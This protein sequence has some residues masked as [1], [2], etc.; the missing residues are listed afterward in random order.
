MPPATDDVLSFLDW[1]D[2]EVDDAGIGAW[3]NRYVQQPFDLNGKPLFSYVL[4]RLGE[5]RHIW[6]QRYHH[7]IIDSYGCHVLCRSLAAIYTAL[8]RGV[9]HALPVHS[10]LDFLAEDQAY[11]ASTA[12]EEH[13]A[14]WAERFAGLPAQRVFP[15]RGTATGGG[16]RT[17]DLPRGLC[18]RLAALARDHGCSPFH[19]HLAALYI[20]L[21][22]S[23]DADELVVGMPV[24]NRRTAAYKRTGG[25]F[26]SVSAMRL[27]FGR[28]LT[29]GGLC[30][31][32]ARELREC[33][34][35]QRFPISEINRAQG[36]DYAAAAQLFDIS[37]SYEKQDYSDIRFDGHS[38]QAVES[39]IA[40]TPLA[41]G[42]HLC[43]F[44]DESDVRAVVEYNHAHLDAAEADRFLR[45]WRHVLDSLPD[46]AAT[47]VWQFPLVS[48]EDR[49]RLAAFNATAADFGP[50]VTP[51]ELVEAQAAR[52]P[53]AVALIYDGQ[54]ISHGALN[55][56]ANALARVLAARGVGPGR[57]V[58]ICMDRGIDIVVAILAVLKA[59]GAYV[60]L[61][62]SYPSARLGFILEDCHPDVV[63]VD[64]LGSAR[65]PEGIE[66]LRVDAG[67]VADNPATV[68][69]SG[70]LAYVFYTSGSTGKPK[71]VMIRQESVFNLVRWMQRDFY[72]GRSFTELLTSSFS[73]DISVQQLFSALASGHTIHIAPEAVRQDPRT[74][75][76]YLRA[77]DIGILNVTP[78]LLAAMMEHDVQGAPALRHVILG[79]EA[80]PKALVEAFDH[81]R[82]ILYNFYGPTEVTVNA[83]WL[84]CDAG[85]A[86]R[87]DD[88]P[89]GRPMA[90]TAVHILDDRRQ[91]LPPGMQ[92]EVCIGGIGVADGYFNRPELTADRFIDHP[93]L[94]RL[95]RAGDVGLWL[96][97]GVVA[98][99]GRRDDQVKVRGY[100]IEL[101]EV[102]GALAAHPAVAE[103]VTV[104]RGEGADRHLASYYRLA[105]D[106]EATPAELR[107]WLSEQ[108]PAH[109]APSFLVALEALPLTP[110]GK[111]DRRA[112]PEPEAVV[113]TE[114][115]G[116]PASA[117][118][119]SVCALFG[120][121]LNQPDFA[122]EGDFFAH[123]GHSL[124]GTQLLVRLHKALNVRLPLHVLFANATPRALARII[125]T[126]APDVFSPIPRLADRPDHAPSRAQW[127]LWAQ[128][129]MQPEDA[130]SAVYHMPGVAELPPGTDVARL[131]A[132]ILAVVARHD[133]LRT[134]F[135]LGDEGLVQ[136]VRPMAAVE[137]R[138]IRQLAMSRQ[139]A[140]AWMRTDVAR[141]FDLARGPLFRVALI[142]TTDAP[143]SLLLFTMHHIISDGWSI[144]LMLD[145]IAELYAGR[146]PDE[147]AVRYRD[148]AAWHNA[149]LDDPA[150]EARHLPYW[151]DTL[152][153]APALALPTDHPRPAAR[154]F[155]GGHV[156][157]RWDAARLHGLD[158]LGQR[159]G[160][161]SFMVLAGLCALLLHRVS[162]QDDIV[163]GTPEAGRDHA[164]LKRV[165]GMFINMLCLRTRIEE[166]DTASDFLRQVREVCMEAQ[167]HRAY[168]FDGLVDRL[169]LPRDAGRHP[170]FDVTVTLEDADAMTLRL[171][172]EKVRVSTVETDTSKFDLTFAFTR[173][174]DGLDGRI[175]F[176]AALFDRST[177]DRLALRLEGIVAA[178]LADD[179]VPVASLSD[180][181]V[182]A[183]AVTAGFAALAALAG[184]EEGV[185]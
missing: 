67:E 50:V 34:R 59:G 85:T 54:S 125:E 115:A 47:P 104:A 132:A 99:L 110:Q 130:R 3:V 82:Q 152:E 90:N 150:F 178:V 51:K 81:S 61:D 184:R 39:E 173:D 106:A 13:R 36:L 92:G 93:E 5:G 171:D 119:A 44:H 77:H 129:S 70:D 63:I 6:V 108:L 27:A 167:A 16:G 65:L 53:E 147:P 162:G 73:F 143:G 95:Y 114:A 69:G 84:T 4:I 117:L 28:E 98:Y 86:A 94:G 26:G 83:T 123:G 10:Y 139:E 168:P 30:R 62:P 172:D 38:I 137:A 71:G 105:S 131:R 24:L 154:S 17:V 35:R 126:S 179:E 48:A 11:A 118:E 43:E 121:V 128:D 56:R 156:A 88:T 57:L 183:P 22:R 159:L 164:D 2:Q 151:R 40:D 160:M 165:P 68:S 37:L 87:Y 32:I 180:D 14:F 116:A 79:A 177:V 127:R 91:L 107:S 102:S 12:F 161:T 124:R 19:V 33:Y 103:A 170:L 134:V 80:L 141:P 146:T 45:L 9:P 31:A 144:G 101:G 78:S 52:T 58:P 142:E 185:I 7:I 140:R 49:A 21:T 149:L 158:A 1:S 15:K 136:T 97:D 181:G 120:E 163:I 8:R 133:I 145:E 20:C 112:L 89:I 109:M 155:A 66:R 23:S 135:R 29:V 76:A 25:L 175:D 148:Y 64:D 182:D 176:A 42:I 74:L 174:P 72:R 169:D 96:D 111:V 55:A 60:P 157:F 46:N 113:R 100:R 138:I 122:P 18:D 153:D 166:T 75:T 41:L